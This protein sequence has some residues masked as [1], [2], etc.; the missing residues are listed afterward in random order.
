M[1]DYDY[2]DYDGDR[3]DARYERGEHRREE[4]E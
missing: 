2:G 3:E 1:Y 4:T